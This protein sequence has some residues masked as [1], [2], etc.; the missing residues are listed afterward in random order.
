MTLGPAMIL[1]AWFERIKQRP[2]NKILITFGRVP[3]IYYLL[4]F[5]VAHGLAILV[6]YM[7]GQPI[8]YQY[9]PNVKAPDGVAFDLWVTYLFWIVGLILLYPL[10]RWFAEIKDRHRKGWLRYL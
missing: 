4:Q 5:Y 7:A 9:K 3:L 8:A 1:L 6:G 2:L 10:C